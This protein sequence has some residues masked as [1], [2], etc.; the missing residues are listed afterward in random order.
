MVDFVLQ[1][2]LLH[3]QNSSGETRSTPRRL[4]ADQISTVASR[5]RAPSTGGGGTSNRTELS[6]FSALILMVKSADVYHAPKT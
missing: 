1:T 4:L 3:L 6:L 5:A 2:W